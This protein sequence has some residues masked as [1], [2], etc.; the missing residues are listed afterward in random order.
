MK[1]DLY[2]DI[3]NNH[4]VRESGNVIENMTADNELSEYAIFAGDME[5]NHRRIKFQLEQLATHYKMVF[6]VDG[7]HHYYGS[8]FHENMKVKIEK[9]CKDFG[10]H[11]KIQFLP[12]KPHVENGVGIVGVNGWYN[13]GLE[14]FSRDA[15]IAMWK[16]MHSDYRMIDFYPFN[17]PD[18]LA[19]MD[20]IQLAKDIEY[21]IKRNATKVVVVTHSIP[22]SNIL[23]IKGD[24]EWDILS[25]SFVNTFME[26]VYE[27]YYMWIKVWC[28]GHTHEEYVR[29]LKTKGHTTMFLCNPC[30]YPFERKKMGNYSPM[31]FEVG[32]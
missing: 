5:D 17:G 13:W 32:K 6:H 2:S 3:H 30:G 9:D 25:G 31:Q 14:N 29:R 7:N 8:Q 19:K 27:K 18:E 20:A 16:R 22:H 28:Y 21:C 24:V 26:A 23:H 11:S 1:F 12:Y 10:T 4:W 15:Q